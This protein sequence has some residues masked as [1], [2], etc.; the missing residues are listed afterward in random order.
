[1]KISLYGLKY[2]FFPKWMWRWNIGW[3]VCSLSSVGG[4][5]F[6]GFFFFF[7]KYVLCHLSVVTDTKIP[8][9]WMLITFRRGLVLRNP[10]LSA[11]W[12]VEEGYFGSWITNVN[13]VLF[14]DPSLFLCFLVF[15]VINDWVSSWPGLFLSSW[16]WKVLNI[17]ALLRSWKAKMSILSVW[18]THSLSI[19]LLIISVSGESI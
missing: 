6:L 2:Y 14:C 16:L 4:V 8:D 3:N 10:C 12:E 18:Y 19:A 1:M 9:N 7:E 13:S 17:E 5:E 11:F 15:K